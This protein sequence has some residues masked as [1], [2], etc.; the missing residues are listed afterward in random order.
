MIARYNRWSF[1]LGVPG[2]ILQVAGVLGIEFDA[3]RSFQVGEARIEWVSSLITFGILFWT[4]GLAAYAM[5]KG[6]A[7]WWGLL[8]LL[9]WVGLYQIW[10][11][12]LSLIGFVVL[13]LLP[14]RS[15][16]SA[17]ESEPDASDW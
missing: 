2:I 13:L 8:G 12:F 4:A 17:V 16:G 14:D 3:P 6:R 7:S 5:A 15:G 1:L 9:G 10:L 11:T